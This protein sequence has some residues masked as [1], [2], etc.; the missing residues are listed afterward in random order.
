MCKVKAIPSTSASWQSY[1]ADVTAIYHDCSEVFPNSGKDPMPLKLLTGYT[2]SAG[3]CSDGAVLPGHPGQAKPTFK[4]VPGPW[5]QIHPTTHAK[6]RGSF[7]Q[8]LYLIRSLENWLTS[9]V[10]ILMGKFSLFWGSLSIQASNLSCRISKKNFKPT[11]R[12]TQTHTSITETF[13]LPT[14]DSRLSLWWQIWNRI[15][16]TGES[17]TAHRSHNGA[18][19]GKGPQ[20]A[21]WRNMETNKKRS[22]K[23]H[24]KRHSTNFV[25][26][27]S[28]APAT[29]ERRRQFLFDFKWALKAR[30]YVRCWY[31]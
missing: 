14:E 5:R 29:K 12:R 28:P 25:S 8:L 18:G 3:S 2:G 22:L 15:N 7:L 1:K 11:K 24:S 26:P 23:L 16:T 21:R 13:F 6:Y 27:S 4:R 31:S 19:G 20:K 9:K 30:S 10:D 17:C